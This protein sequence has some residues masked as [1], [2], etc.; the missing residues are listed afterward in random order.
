MTWIDNLCLNLSFLP[1][2]LLHECQKIRY[3]PAE[4]R[5]CDIFF[6]VFSIRVISITLSSTSLILL[7]VISSLPQ[8]DPMN[9]S[10]LK[11]HSSYISI[12]VFKYFTVLWQTFHQCFSTRPFFFPPIFIM[13]IPEAPSANSN[14][15]SGIARQLARRI[16]WPESHF[17]FFHVLYFF[18]C[19][20]NNFHRR[21][22][23]T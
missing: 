6:S 19:M 8:A 3:W 17:F 21:T 15:L 10:F 20:P 22:A 7:S 23:E 5:H 16:S 4:L 1:K 14:S 9:S 2:I 12:W 11:K 13:V 18:Y